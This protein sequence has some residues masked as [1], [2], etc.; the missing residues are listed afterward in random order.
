MITNDI[1]YQDTE[2]SI[3]LSGFS[4]DW[5]F[6][7]EPAGEQANFGQVAEVLSIIDFGSIVTA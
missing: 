5:R 7:N 4:I 2:F 1:R 3:T 6:I